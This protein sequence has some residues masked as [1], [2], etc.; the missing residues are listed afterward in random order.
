MVMRQL[1]GLLVAVIVV[2][3]KKSDNCTSPQYSYTYSERKK[4]DTLR[5][6]G[7]FLSTQINPGNNTVFSYRFTGEFCKDRSDGPSS[8]YLIFESPANAAQFEYSSN[9]IKDIPCYYQYNLGDGSSTEALKILEGV[10]SGIKVSRY[11]WSIEV[12]VIIP[13]MNK[14]LSFKKTFTLQ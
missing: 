14:T 4:I 7:Y 1:I 3:C 8:E 6:G 10:I 5:P 13:N 11:T 9:N 12:N 2:S